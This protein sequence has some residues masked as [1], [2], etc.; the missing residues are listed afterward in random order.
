MKTTKPVILI[1]FVFLAYMSNAQIEEEVKNFVDTTRQT[2]NNGR[3]LLVKEV[4]DGNYSKAIKVHDYLKKV[5][6]DDTCSPFTYSEELHF[7]IITTQWDDLVNQAVNI[8]DYRKTLCYPRLESIGYSLYHKIK[9]NIDEYSKKIMKSDLT[10]EEKD[11][12]GIYIYLLKNE[13]RDKTYNQK[14]KDFRDKYEKTKFDDFISG[15]LPPLWRKYSFTI[16]FGSSGFFPKAPLQESFPE[17]AMFSMS[18]DF[19]VGDVY[20]SLLLTGGSPKLEAPFTASSQN[21][22][23]DFEKGEHFSYLEAG[24]NVGYFLVRSENFHIAPYGSISS[25]TLESDIYDDEDKDEVELI[26]SFTYGFGVHTEIKLTEWENTYSYYYSYGGKAS[27]S[28]LSLKIE[29]GHNL[30][31]NAKDEMFEGNVSY[32]RV[33]LIWGFGDF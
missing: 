1:F 5:T 10:Q 14:L 19:N 22:S 33:S 3:Q 7:F 27:K 30:I 28:F 18:L 4:K 23:F 11:L 13:E 26:N 17:T 16:G 31:T 9:N 2:V 32:A 6:S 15:Y 8:N 21:Q 24:L 12:F 25:T 20:T 29:G